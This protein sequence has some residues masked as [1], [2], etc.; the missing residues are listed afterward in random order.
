MTSETENNVID[1]KSK[2]HD[3]VVQMSTRLP[4]TAQSSTPEAGDVTMTEMACRDGVCF[5]SWKP[6]K[7]AA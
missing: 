2:R 3:N 4:T 1:I 7:P 5:L 6:R